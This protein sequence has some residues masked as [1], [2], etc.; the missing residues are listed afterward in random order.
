LTSLDSS[1]PE[2][3]DAPRAAPDHHTL[4]LEND[5]VRVL[6]TRIRA[7]DRTPLHTHRWPS[8]LYILSWSSFIRRD[9]SGAVVLDSRTVPELAVPPQVLW[10]PAL[11]AHTLENTGT[12]NLRV[13]SVE[14]KSI[15][16]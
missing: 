13:I 2:E 1:W 12:A 7:G 4:L 16:G 14:L 11:P 3:L 15:V 10:S 6:D 8:V 9:A 5:A